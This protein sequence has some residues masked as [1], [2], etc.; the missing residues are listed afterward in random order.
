MSSILFHNLIQHLHSHPTYYSRL[1]TSNQTNPNSTLHTPAKMQF[2]VLV[3]LLPLLAAAV[4]LS[5]FSNSADPNTAAI[6]DIQALKN[7]LTKLD[8]A[9]QKYDGQL[10][11]AMPL[12]EDATNAQEDVEKA[13]KDSKAI[14]S[15]T[16]EVKQKLTTAMRELKPEAE[17]AL[18][19]LVEKVPR[20]D[21]YDL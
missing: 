20:P 11:S 2:K 14:T 10:A 8:N 21:P 9:V 3:T 6:E 17:S 5:S 13:L 7:D 16:P 1:Y 15:L 12:K 18:Q 4:P 19:H